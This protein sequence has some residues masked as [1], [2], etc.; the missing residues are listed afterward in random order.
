[1]A[2]GRC[3]FPSGARIAGRNVTA[4]RKQMPIA[5][6]SAAPTVENTPSLANTIARNVTATVAADAAITLPIDDSALR[7][8]ASESSPRRTKS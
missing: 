7:T 5:T 6:A 2:G 1:V 8:A 4:A 3:G